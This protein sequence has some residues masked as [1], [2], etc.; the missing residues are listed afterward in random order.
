MGN[1]TKQILES[2]ARWMR[3]NDIE[4]ICYDDEYNTVCIYSRG[5]KIA[6]EDMLN[7]DWTREKYDVKVIEYTEEMAGI[8]ID[9]RPIIEE[10]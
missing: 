6:F 5:V 8:Q 4:R 10:S 1:K 9:L 2:L 7:A 3:D